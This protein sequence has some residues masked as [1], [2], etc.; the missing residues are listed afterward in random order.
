[1][2]VKLLAIFDIL[3]RFEVVFT[4]KIEF[5]YASNKELIKK[6]ELLEKKLEKAK[7]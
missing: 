1:M 6:L 2:K 7:K 3:D 4:E 5:L